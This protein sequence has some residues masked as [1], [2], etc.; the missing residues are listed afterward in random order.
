MLAVW[1]RGNHII[2]KLVGGSKSPRVYYACIGTR[3]PAG[4]VEQCHQLVGTSQARLT[5]IGEWLFAGATPF[6]CV[7]RGQPWLGDVIDYFN[8]AA[9]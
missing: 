5:M 8:S 2:I 3:I 6:L 1:R 9:T 7:W 4:N